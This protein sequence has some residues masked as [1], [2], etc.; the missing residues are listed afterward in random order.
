MGN[1]RPTMPPTTRELVALW[2]AKIHK[3]ERI[4][5]DALVQCYPKSLTREQLSAKTGYS[6]TSSTFDNYVRS[7]CRNHLAARDGNV[8]T[9]SDTL[10][11]A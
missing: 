6:L 3:G 8:I 4:M 11:P 7:L 9:A 5:L 2:G 10:F 1:D